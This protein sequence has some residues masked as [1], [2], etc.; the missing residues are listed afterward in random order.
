M[1]MTPHAYDPPCLTSH[2]MTSTQ[3]ITL[4]GRSESTVREAA[5]VA[6]VTLYRCEEAEIIQAVNGLGMAKA[7]TRNLTMLTLD[8]A[9]RL[10]KHM[11]GNG[12][13]GAEALHDE[14]KSL[15]S[16]SK[17]PPPLRHPPWENQQAQPLYNAAQPEPLSQPATQQYNF[18]SA[19]PEVILLPHEHREAYAL[20]IVPR[21]ARVEMDQFVAWSAAPI[22]LER[23][24]K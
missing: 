20:R 23:S 5:N 19:P 12:S 21:H 13:P 24:D 22:N 11:D 14:I 16:T 17:G 8:G 9:R 1:P 10:C 6:G 4:L 7:H 18:P 3:V 2:A 15:I